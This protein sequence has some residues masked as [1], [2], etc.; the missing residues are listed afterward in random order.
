MRSERIGIVLILVQQLLFT[1]DTAAIH[2]LAGS[3]S[4]WQLGL[5]RSIGGLVLALCLAPSI[6]WS[7]F[8][9]HHPALQLL[10]A[11]T[12]IGYIWVLVYSFATMPFADATAI[13]YSQAI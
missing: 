8:R 2:S 7:V 4:L 6:G 5:F 10:R 1:L 11:G 9:T 13:G 3:V 12:T